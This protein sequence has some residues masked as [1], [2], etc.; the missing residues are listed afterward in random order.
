VTL[1]E[2]VTARVPRVRHARWADPLTYYRLPLL[3][4][5]VAGDWVELYDDR[6]QLA[7]GVKPGTA[8]LLIS[9]AGMN[10]GFV[11]YWGPVSPFEQDRANFAR[12]YIDF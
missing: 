6:Q 11:P 5:L 1:R 10:G 3:P 9:V 4:G 8:R 2:A 12:T 7:T